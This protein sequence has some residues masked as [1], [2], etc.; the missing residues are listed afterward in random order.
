M[1]EYDRDGDGK[2]DYAEFQ[3]LMSQSDLD[4]MVLP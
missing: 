4:A 2:L 1:L 3:N